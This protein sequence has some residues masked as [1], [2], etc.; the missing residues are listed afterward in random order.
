MPGF[1]GTGPQGRGPMTGRGFGNCRPAYQQARVPATPSGE[2]QN[3]MTNENA[4]VYQSPAQGQAPVY[5]L[6]RGGIP[7]GGGRGFG[8]GGRGGRRGRCFW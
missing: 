5:G 7:C 6:G 2:N 4:P 3:V 8:N 1:D